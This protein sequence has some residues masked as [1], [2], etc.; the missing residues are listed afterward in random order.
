[1]CS[2][3]EQREWEESRQAGTTRTPRI[4]L[5]AQRIDESEEILGN[6]IALR[7]T[8]QTLED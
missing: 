8:F 1:M 6:E 2:S 5:K 7:P 3:I 4:I